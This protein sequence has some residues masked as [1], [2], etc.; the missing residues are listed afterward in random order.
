MENIINKVEAIASSWDAFEKK[1]KKFEEHTSNLEQEFKNYSKRVDNLET[2]I[3]EAHIDEISLEE[4]SFN[5]FLKTGEES[6]G[7]FEIKSLTSKLD[8]A[9]HLISP[10]ISKKI[11]DEMN[12]ISPMRR[13]CGVEA[14]STSSLDV[15]IEE[16]NFGYGWVTET[17]E[18]RETENS[19]ILKKRIPVFEVYAQPK[20]SQQMLDDAEI[21]L[22]VW[23]SNKLRERFIEAEDDAFINGDGLSRPSGIVS[24]KELDSLK[25]SDKNKITVDD[26]YTLMESLNEKFM[27]GASFLMHKST[28][29]ELRKL[30]DKDG[31]FIWNSEINKP[32][33][34]S[35][36]GVP[37]VTSSHMPS[38]KE[39]STIIAFGNFKEGYKIVDRKGISIMRDP[40]TE[41]P[42]V[43]FYATKRVGGDVIRKEAIKLLK[44]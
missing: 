22:E 7:N 32:F 25:L 6:Y 43:K 19:K 37:V 28:L 5:N 41:K 39:G 16:G 26:I 21:N 23:L 20:A 40:F 24:C 30:K 2:I 29:F 44:C 1:Y 12:A 8:D 33:S 13:L 36:L 31:R 11:V 15:L 38:F 4:K 17:D 18:R 3:S 14:I 42:F 35:L 9:G 27:A 34:D 10:A